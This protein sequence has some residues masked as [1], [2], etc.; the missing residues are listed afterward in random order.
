MEP[1][2]KKRLDY[3]QTYNVLEEL[4]E[5]AN[6]QHAKNIFFVESEEL[7]EM[8]YVSEESEAKWKQF[9]S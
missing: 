5:N 7:R 9:R 8:V 3:N 4:L 6:E 1:S 2:A